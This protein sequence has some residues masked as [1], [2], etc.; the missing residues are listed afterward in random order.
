M[1]TPPRPARATLPPGPPGL[2]LLG[3]L[4]QLSA[5]G[6]G[7]LHGLARAYGPAAT[8][9]LGTQTVV[10]LSRPD[11]VR[12]VLIEPPPGLSCAEFQHILRPMLGRGLLTTD[13]AEHRRLRRLIQ[14]AFVPR[15]V[16]AYRDAM[17]AHTERMLEGWRPGATIDVGRELQRLTLG[18]MAEV[19]VGVRR[20]QEVDALGAAISSSSR[21]TLHRWL[22]LALLPAEQAAGGVARATAR[23]PL[24]AALGDGR[25]ADDLLISN[26]LA[27]LP[28]TPLR[29][30]ARTRESIDAVINR[31]IAERRAA[32]AGARDDGDVLA[33]LLGAGGTG[34]EEALDDREIRDQLITLLAAGYGTTAV[35]LTWALYLLSIHPPVAAALRA[36]LRRVLGGRAPTVP[37]LEQLPY[38]TQ[39]WHETLRLYPPVW[40]IGRLCHQQ[41]TVAGYT[42]PAGALLLLSPWVTHRLPD[43]FKHPH[44]FR[45]E[46]FDPE[47][48][49]R[50][51]P[52]AFFPFGAGARICIG[53]AFATLEGRIL[54][55]TILQR[56]DPQ[57]VP[58]HPVA[59]Q[60]LIVLRPAHGLPMTLRPLP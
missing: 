44:R 54:L 14:P 9:R 51:P 33:A 11:A 37:E 49:E 16:A 7:Y 53:G 12:E 22:A 55:A 2:P 24:L 20:P 17:V 15:R 47:H 31:V 38:L 29:R 8:Y 25:L 21:F 56:V 30:L 39:V 34:D 57:V 1:Q 18:I 23:L 41:V 19:V 43:L 26:P 48:G 10:L 28:G 27:R 45:P 52:H 6:L 59:P 40:A 13:G 3:H 5:H 60:P 4:P 50:H 35:A 46:R 32:P 58:G 42:V 36:E